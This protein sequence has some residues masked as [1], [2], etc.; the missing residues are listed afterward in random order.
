MAIAGPVLALGYESSVSALWFRKFG[1]DRQGTGDGLSI[2]LVKVKPQTII[3]AEME[4]WCLHFF[5]S[6]DG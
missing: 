4:T 2:G 3:L 5:G 6:G 1:S